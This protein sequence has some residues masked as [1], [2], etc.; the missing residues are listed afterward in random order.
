MP[1]NTNVD[2]Q[3]YVEKKEKWKLFQMDFQVGITCF[4]P[5]RER[6]QGKLDLTETTRDLPGHCSDLSRILAANRALEPVDSPSLKCSLSTTIYLSA[7]L[8]LHRDN[9]VIAHLAF[10][11][12]LELESAQRELLLDFFSP[13]LTLQSHIES[14]WI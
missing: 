7:L 3:E 10:H 9:R 14:G 13:H 2:S 6:E 4:A 11:R 8:I 12:H 5:H 1:L